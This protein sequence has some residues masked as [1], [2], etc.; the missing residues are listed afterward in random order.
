MTAVAWTLLRMK[1][2]GLGRGG[3]A[4]F[5]RDGTGG[6]C[7]GLG[8]VDAVG[9]LC[10][11]LHFLRKACGLGRLVQHGGPNDRADARGAPI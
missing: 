1:S 8:C 4:T 10:C 5:W 9:W 7:L 2:G 3:S 11:R 6:L